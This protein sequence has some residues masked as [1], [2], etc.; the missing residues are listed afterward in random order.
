MGGFQFNNSFLF[1]EQT[2]S[3][4]TFLHPLLTSLFGSIVQMK[5]SE[6]KTLVAFFL[7]SGKSN[8]RMRINEL[9]S[10]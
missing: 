7:S 9:L 8:L 4:E 6:K 2:S 3:L 10:G 5:S 1:I